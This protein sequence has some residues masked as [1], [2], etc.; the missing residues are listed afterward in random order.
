M[1]ARDWF[2]VGIRLLGV[3]VI[4]DAFNFLVGFFARRMVESEIARE[5]GGSK[6]APAYYLV[7]AVCLAASGF[8]L[9]WGA[10]RLTRWA[11]NEPAAEPKD[12]EITYP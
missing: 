12:D 3:Y 7:Y 11:F 5:L 6:S 9:I 2:G 4:Y 10:E 1:R 8:I